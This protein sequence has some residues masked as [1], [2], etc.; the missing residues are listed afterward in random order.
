MYE[1]LWQGRGE[2]SYALR[3]EL[4]KHDPKNP[5]LVP[6]SLKPFVDKKAAEVVTKAGFV[7]VPETQS[8]RYVPL[9]NAKRR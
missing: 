5:L 8:V 7:Y 9:A 4:Q 1:A 6:G 3:Q 2:A